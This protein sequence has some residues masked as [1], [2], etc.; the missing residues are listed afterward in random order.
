M[1][2]V[3]FMTYKRVHERG[4]KGI[5]KIYKITIGEEKNGE[6]IW[7]EVYKCERKNITL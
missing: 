4:W 5:T 6:N 1:L 3:H 2:A 7:Y